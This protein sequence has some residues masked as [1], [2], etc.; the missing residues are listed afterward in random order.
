L[1]QKREGT[2]GRE[3]RIETRTIFLWFFDL[4]KGEKGLWMQNVMM[5]DE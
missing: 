1:K 2:G 5:K 3:G 4:E